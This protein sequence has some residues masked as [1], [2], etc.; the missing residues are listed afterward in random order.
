MNEIIEVE[1][2]ILTPEELEADKPNSAKEK[3]EKAKK[4]FESV[5]KAYDELILTRMEISP[6]LGTPKEAAFKAF[7]KASDTYEDLVTTVAEATHGMAPA[8]WTDP[9]SF[10]DLDMM[11]HNVRGMTFNEMEDLKGTLL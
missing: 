11:G 4:L 2:P 6:A 7:D 5:Q 3:I 10:D 1:R 8:F 9:K